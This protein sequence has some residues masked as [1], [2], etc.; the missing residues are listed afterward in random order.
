MHRSAYPLLTTLSLLLSLQLPSTAQMVP[1]DERTIHLRLIGEGAEPITYKSGEVEVLEPEVLTDGSRSRLEG[2]YYRIRELVLPDRSLFLDSFPVRTRINHAGKE[3]RLRLN[4]NV[5]EIS[6]RDGIYHVPRKFEPLFLLRGLN[7]ARIPERNIACFEVYDESLDPEWNTV[8]S[9]GPP[10]P[11]LVDGRYDGHSI[12][13]SGPPTVARDWSTGVLRF[14]IPY[15]TMHSTIGPEEALYTDLGGGAE[16]RSLLIPR[17]NLEEMFFATPQLGWR[18]E[19]VRPKGII[20]VERVHRSSDGGATWSID[21]EMTALGI[22]SAAP[23]DRERAWFLGVSPTDD[24][25]EWTL[26]LYTGSREGKG[27][28]EVA[29]PKAFDRVV[30]AD[31]YIPEVFGVGEEGILLSFD[32]WESLRHISFGRDGSY[33]RVI[34]IPGKLHRHFGEPGETGWM[35]VEEQ[36]GGTDAQIL[37]PWLRDYYGRAF[38]LYR[39]SAD[40]TAIGT[41]LLSATRLY[42]IS[43][44]DPQRG[45]VIGSTFILLTDDGG[46]SWRYLPTSENWW[47]HRGAHPIAMLWPDLSTLRVVTTWGFYDLDVDRLPPMKY[48]GE[49]LPEER[50]EVEIE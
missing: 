47:A 18:I 37:L 9:W 28:R 21:E 30:P 31:R 33:D 15:L 48:C 4:A 38:R 43:F 36:L 41:N 14:T 10:S 24:P 17:I 3:M 7:G 34:E 22:C 46:A 50:R 13:K 45:A 32:G 44:A 40:G 8:D 39:L 49:S 11:L 19:F 5:G 6:F 26:R 42:D 23:R 2:S 27:L 16:Y 25:T 12:E 35:I 1:I 29:W 20:E